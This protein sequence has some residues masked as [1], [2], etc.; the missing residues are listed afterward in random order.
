MDLLV[1][2]WIFCSEQSVAKLKLQTPPLGQNTPNTRVCVH[3]VGHCV[4]IYGV[5]L[6]TSAAPKYNIYGRD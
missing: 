2:A 4:Q 6:Y 5:S 1:D 3:D